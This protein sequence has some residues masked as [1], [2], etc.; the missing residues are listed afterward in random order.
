M[1][2]ADIGFAKQNN[3]RKIMAV[4]SSIGPGAL[5]M[6]T[7]TGLA[8]VNRILVL[9]LPGD[10]FACRQQDP[11]LQQLEQFYDYSITCNDAFKPVCRHCDRI[12]RPEQRLSATINAMR[13]L[14]NPVDTRAVCLVLPLDVQVEDW[15][16]PMNLGDIGI[17]DG[18]AANKIAAE[19]DLVI[20][21]RTRLFDFTIDSKWA[22]QNP[23]VDFISLNVN[24]FD[25]YKMNSEPFLCDAVSGLISIG[26]K[27]RD[28]NY[29]SAYSQEIET[30]KTEW[31]IK[32]GFDS[33]SDGYDTW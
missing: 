3:R 25:A 5:N 7:A 9:L 1:A 29:K 14:T 23:D 24:S 6:V 18:L 26:K 32:V 4:T 19:A 8:T 17:T 33:M 27:L 31:N 15:D 16:Y 11:V 12:N 20:A 21:V 2:H 28:K 30:V 22:F 10:I 13:V